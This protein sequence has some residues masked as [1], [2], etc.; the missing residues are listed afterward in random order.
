MSSVPTID[1]LDI[2]A[3]MNDY[4]YALSDGDCGGRNYFE[5][6]SLQI[7]VAHV[8]FFE[9]LVEVSDLVYLVDAHLVGF[10]DVEKDLH[11]ITNNLLVFTP[12]F[13]IEGVDPIISFSKDIILFDSV[14]FLY[15]FTLLFTLSLLSNVI[16]SFI[17][18]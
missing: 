3:I 13:K 14:F 1:V 16:S 4:K 5:L 9:V 15:T 7:M 11:L 12:G 6:W 8:V 10:V 17:L 2:E 18:L